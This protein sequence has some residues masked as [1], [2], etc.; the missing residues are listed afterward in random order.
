MVIPDP[1]LPQPLAK[2]DAVPTHTGLNMLP[3][4]AWFTTN[5]DTEK[6]VIYVK[7]EIERC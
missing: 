5:M 7:N 1:A 6:P 2:A 4:Q 3:T